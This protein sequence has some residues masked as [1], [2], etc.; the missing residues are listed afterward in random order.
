MER[1]FGEEKVGP[2][3]HGDAENGASGR[4]KVRPAET[5]EVGWERV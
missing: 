3:N 1:S 4:K 5:G 2:E